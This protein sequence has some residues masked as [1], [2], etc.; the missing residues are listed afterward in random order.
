ML[1]FIPQALLENDFAQYMS[2]EYETASTDA[3]WIKTY[4]GAVLGTEQAKDVRLLDLGGFFLGLYATVF[5]RVLIVGFDVDYSTMIFAWLPSLFVVLDAPP[6]LPAPP[7]G[8]AVPAPRP[9]RSGL[10]V[11]HV[12]FSYPGTDRWVLRDVSF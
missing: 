2:N 6:D 7:P 1:V 10:L 12:S 8:R 3:R 5:G 4:H 9:V 11:D